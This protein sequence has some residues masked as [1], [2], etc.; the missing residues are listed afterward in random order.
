MVDGALRGATKVYTTDD[1]K[2]QLGEI[3]I[4]TDLVQEGNIEAHRVKGHGS[5]ILDT[6]L[7]RDYPAG[8]EVRTLMGT[9]RVYENGPKQYVGYDNGQKWIARVVLPEIVQTP[10]G[11]VPRVRSASPP[12]GTSVPVFGAQHSERAEP[13]DTRGQPDSSRT[14]GF[15]VP[16]QGHAE[17]VNPGGSV[18]GSSGLNLGS[19]NVGAEASQNAVPGQERREQA[20]AASPITLSDERILGRY[21]TRGSQGIG[22]EDHASVLQDIEIGVLEAVNHTDAKEKCSGLDS[23]LPPLP[24]GA[25]EDKGQVHVRA[26]LGRWE[27]RLILFYSTISPKAGAYIK[28]VLAGVAKTLPLY[29]KDYNPQIIQNMN[30]AEVG[31]HTIAEA[32]TCRFLGEMKLPHDSYERAASIRLEPCARIQL[33]MH[34]D[35]ILPPPPVELKRCQEYFMSPP[36]NVTKPNLVCDEIMRWKGMGW[37]LR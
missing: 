26:S 35:R 4:F 3:V 23:A 11:T 22:E 29:R 15:T 36:G 1:K 21:F 25:D 14:P 18:L 28:G 16:A 30:C 37:R 19:G 24:Q 5:L 6:P 32:H 13:S 20:R 8:S 10:A 34:Y 12:Q 33:I 31:F 17:Q 9:E 2:F 27:S 7:T